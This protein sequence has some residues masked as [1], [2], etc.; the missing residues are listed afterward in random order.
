[1]SARNIQ[2]LRNSHISY[3]DYTLVRMGSMPR[4]SPAVKLEMLRMP[5][6][7]EMAVIGDVSATSSSINYSIDGKTPLRNADI[8]K[9]DKEASLNV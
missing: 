2:Q 3:Q 1:M 6:F 9:L 4:S 5:P 8:V 7:K